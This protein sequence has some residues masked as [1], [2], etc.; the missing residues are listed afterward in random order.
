[1]KAKKQI[2]QDTYSDMKEAQ[3]AGKTLTYCR[4]P[5]KMEFENNLIIVI[6]D[7]PSKILAIMKKLICED[8]VLD[9]LN[10]ARRLQERKL[11]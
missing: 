6:L 2:T 7:K 11:V 9:H 4:I 10:V 8:G 5:H 1:M 3:V